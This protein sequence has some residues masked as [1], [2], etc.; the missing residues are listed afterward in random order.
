VSAILLVTTADDDFGVG[1]LADA[2]IGAAVA[3]LFSQVLFSPEPVALLRRSE[4]AALKD[5]ARSLHEGA[6]ARTGR[7]HTSVCELFPSH[8][9]AQPPSR[10]TPTLTRDRPLTTSTT[11]EASLAQPWHWFAAI[12][13]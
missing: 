9:R 5:M 2:A 8:Q 1:R 3:L 10:V 13:H 4:E 11:A 7:R 6:G 12:G